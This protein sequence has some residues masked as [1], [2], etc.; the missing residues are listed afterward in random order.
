M[1]SRGV[2]AEWD[3]EICEKKQ[4]PVTLTIICILDGP[5]LCGPEIWCLERTKTKLTCCYKRVNYFMMFFF[6]FIYK[7]TAVALFL[8]CCCT[9]IIQT[10]ITKDSLFYAHAEI[11]ADY[12]YFILLRKESFNT[13]IF[14][15]F[16]CHFNF[17]S[18]FFSH[19]KFNFPHSTMETFWKLPL[20]SLLAIQSS[21]D[22]LWGGAF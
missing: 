12:F 6:Y 19:F 14:L 15:S 5:L 2:L 9:H 18:C 3:R 22:L 10:F 8:F 11:I 4:T 17:Y 13:Y 7:R 16:L 21:I 1:T 20:D